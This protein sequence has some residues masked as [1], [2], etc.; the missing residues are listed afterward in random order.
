MTSRTSFFPDDDNDIELA[1]HVSKAFLP[2]ITSD[3]MRATVQ[4]NAEKFRVSEMGGIYATEQMLQEIIE[5]CA[6]S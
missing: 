5:S 3:S 2:G 1:L 6:T 4:N